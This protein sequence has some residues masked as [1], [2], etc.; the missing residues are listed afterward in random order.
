MRRGGISS[1]FLKNR[2]SPPLKILSQPSIPSFNP[3]LLHYHFHC[4]TTYH[5]QQETRSHV[6]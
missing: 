2:P 6:K 1:L 4:S 5:Q 3:F